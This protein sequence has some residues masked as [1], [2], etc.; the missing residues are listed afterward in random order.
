M[1]Q[2]IFAEN[3]RSISL[4]AYVTKDGS[5]TSQYTVPSTQINIEKSFD[6]C[7]WRLPI[8]AQTAYH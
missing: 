5:Y 2:Q 4:V 6:C 1:A 7:Q 8:S 3:L